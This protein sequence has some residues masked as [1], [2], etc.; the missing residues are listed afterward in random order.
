MDWQVW[1]LNFLEFWLGWTA[2]QCRFLLEGTFSVAKFSNFYDDC[3]NCSFFLPSNITYQTDSIIIL[4]CPAKALGQPLSWPSFR[5]INNKLRSEPQARLGNN[6]AALRP[7]TYGSRFV[8]NKNYCCSTLSSCF[9]GLGRIFNF[10]NKTF[11]L[12]KTILGLG[13]C[14]KF[15]FIPHTR[16]VRDFDRRSLSSGNNSAYHPQGLRQVTFQA[17]IT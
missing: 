5:F 13:F 14:G 3:S 17:S 7:S 4:L 11:R 12:T 9:N 16:L 15:V 10:F 2:R 8:H 1:L 6:G